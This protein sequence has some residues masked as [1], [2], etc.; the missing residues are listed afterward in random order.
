MCSETAKKQLW[1]CFK[2]LNL[3]SDM[4]MK[5]QSIRASDVMNQNLNRM[6]IHSG[7]IMNEDS[8]RLLERGGRIVCKDVTHKRIEKKGKKVSSLSLSLWKQHK[9]PESLHHQNKSQEKEVKEVK[10]EEGGDFC[11]QWE[12]WLTFCDRNISETALKLLSYCSE[13]ALSE[14]VTVYWTFQHKMLQNCSEIALNCS[15]KA[16]KLF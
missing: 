1:N 4:Q 14:F 5:W 3:S 9:S 10:E 8:V 16:L 2:I 13:T 6:G 7:Q 11:C 15:E 12:W